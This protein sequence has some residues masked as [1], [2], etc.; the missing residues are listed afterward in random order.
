LILGKIERKS[1][2]KIRYNANKIIKSEISNPALFKKLTKDVYELR[3]S[4]NKKKYRLLGFINKGF[5]VFTH[6][7]I[8]KTSKMPTKEIDKG[9][10]KQYLEKQSKY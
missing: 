7:I 3:T 10:K 5:I 1:N 8:K 9:I 6:G 4:Y 2:K